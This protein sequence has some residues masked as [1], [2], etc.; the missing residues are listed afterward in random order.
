MHKY[1]WNLQY[2]QLLITS[3]SDTDR[4]WAHNSTDDK[5]LE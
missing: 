4:H 1:F 2:L 3:D 5:F